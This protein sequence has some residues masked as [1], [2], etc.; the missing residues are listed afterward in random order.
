MTPIAL[1]FGKQRR[2]DM[3]K[4]VGLMW[5]R[6]KRGFLRNDKGT[7]GIIAGLSMVGICLAIGAGIDFGR[8]TSAHSRLSAALDVAALHVAGMVEKTDAQLTPIAQDVMLKNYGGN[9]Y[10][11]VSGFSLETQPDGKTL[12]VSATVTVKTWFMSLGGIHTVDALVRTE[13]IKGSGGANVEVALVLDNT[14][15]MNEVAGGQVK[16]DALREAAADFIK[17]VIQDPKD[18]PP[19]A[20][21]YSKA[22]IVPYSANVDP[23]SLLG[24]VVRPNSA[25][26]GFSWGCPTYKYTVGK[27]TYTY[28]QKPCVTER[29]GVDAFSDTDMATSRAMY[30]YNQACVGTPIQLLTSDKPALQATIADMVAGGS[31]AGHIGIQWGVQMLSANSTL[32]TVAG[33]P[34]AKPGAYNDDKIKK[35]M[36]IMTDGIFNTW[37]CNGLNNSDGN[38]NFKLL[39]GGCN[40]TNGDSFTQAKAT[41]TSAKANGIEIYFV[42]VA[43]PADPGVDAL[44]ASCSTD[45]SHIIMAA[46]SA[47]LKA[48]FA[49]IAANLTSMR[50]SM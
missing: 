22:A 20:L 19:N 18:Q 50:L 12:R 8:V 31:T 15:S 13:A 45:A 24:S 6:A 23:G 38:G 34:T 39:P 30:N 44:T 1:M 33:Q 41:C 36:I 32:A 43:V 4:A 42:G 40:N 28:T 37:H 25:P 47:A 11:T 16:M 35:V 26:C 5:K 9:S 21:Y 48:A 10:D 2:Q 27:N 17:I 46:D 7:M 49:K 14:G 29:S 3:K